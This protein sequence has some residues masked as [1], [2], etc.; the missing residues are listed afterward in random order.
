MKKENSCDRLKKIIKIRNLK[1]IDI[2]RKAQG[3]SSKYNTS[4][5]PNDLSQYLSGK[6]LPS[7]KKLSILAEILNTNEV[8]L[9][10][11][12]VPMSPSMNELDNKDLNIHDVDRVLGLYYKYLSDNE[13]TFIKNLLLERINEYEKNNSNDQF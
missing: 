5:N 13:I 7:Q 12:D 6:V 1:Q 11:Y 8:W 10:G 2:V 4:I 9:M 3:L